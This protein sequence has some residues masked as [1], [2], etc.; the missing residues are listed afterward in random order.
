MKDEIYY[1]DQTPPELCLRL[2]EY[3][4][5]EFGDTVWE[6]FRGEGAF[7]NAIRRKTQLTTWSEIE[8]GKDYKD[9]EGNFDWI[10][11]NPPFKLDGKSSFGRL[12]MELAHRCNKG[13][14]FLGNDYC[15]T[16][17]TTSRMKK[18]NDIGLYLTK[19]IL[20]NVKKWRGRYYFIIFTR[21]ETSAMEYLSESY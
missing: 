19:I 16:A 13:F 21:S 15:F 12:F 4:P 11:T 5:I 7:Y 6:P 14:A 17:L 10:I 1:R 3:V 18:L 8:D 20:C 2:I 9:I